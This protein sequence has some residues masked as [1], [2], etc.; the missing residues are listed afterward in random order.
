MLKYHIYISIFINFFFIDMHFSQL[1]IFEPIASCG[2]ALW[3]VTFPTI[4]VS[5]RLMG[6][7]FL[8]QFS[9]LLATLFSPLRKMNINKND[10]LN[11]GWNEI[12]CAFAWYNLCGLANWNTSIFSRL[13]LRYSN[14]FLL[15]ETFLACCHQIRNIWRSN[16]TGPFY[17]N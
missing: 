1:C 17:A 7:I 6:K 16:K 11:E 13:P 4:P 2:K 12:C 10:M 15:H 8:T 9:C 14:S 5:W 3:I